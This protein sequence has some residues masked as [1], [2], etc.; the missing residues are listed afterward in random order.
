MHED[1]TG[2]RDQIFKDLKKRSG[3]TTF[4]HALARLKVRGAHRGRRQR[5]RPLRNLKFSPKSGNKAQKLRRG[6]DSRQIS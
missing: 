3:G 1:S 6:N 2:G 4:L 5:S